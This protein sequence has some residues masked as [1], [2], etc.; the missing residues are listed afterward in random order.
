MR[1]GNVGDLLI[2]FIEDVERRLSFL[3]VKGVVDLG[4][5]LST[6]KTVGVALL[7]VFFIKNGVS[8]AYAK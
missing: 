7:I 4:F 8:V 2:F 3:S 6:L 1:F 5:A